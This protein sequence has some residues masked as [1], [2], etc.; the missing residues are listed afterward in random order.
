M[1]SSSTNLEF[2]YDSMRQFETTHHGTP[3]VVGEKFMS[4]T[5]QDDYTN[6]A[7]TCNHVPPEFLEHD[8]RRFFVLQHNAKM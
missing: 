8:D 6:Y 4:D 5:F 1:L 2:E 7:F 3:T